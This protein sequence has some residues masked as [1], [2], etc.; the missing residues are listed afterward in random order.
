M[1]MSDTNPILLFMCCAFPIPF[2]GFPDTEA[3]AVFPSHLVMVE[4]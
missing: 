1:E 2:L 3:I 4:E